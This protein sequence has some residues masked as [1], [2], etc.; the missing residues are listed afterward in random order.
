MTRSELMRVIAEPMRT[1]RRPL[2]RSGLLSVL[3]I[4]VELTQPWPLAIAVDTVITGDDPTPDWFPVTGKTALLALCAVAV[5]ALRAASGLLELAATRSA[6]GAAEQVGAR[7]RAAVFERSMA[8]SLRWHDGLPGG[9]LVSRLTTDVGR[10]L[11]AVVALAVGLIPDVLTLVGVLVLLIAVDPGLAAV[12]A[13]VLPALAVL[14]VLQRRRVRTAQY[15]VRV[16]SGRLA[17]TTTDLIRNVRAV[18]AFGRADRAALIFADRNRAVLDVGLQAVAVE[19]RWA[20]VGDVVLAVGSGLVLLFGGIE[21]VHGGLSVGGLLVVL[22]YLKELYG[23]V[24]SLTRLSTV[25]AKAEASATRVAAVL[26]CDEAVQDAPDAQPA[27]TS[28][29]TIRLDGVAFGYDTQHRVLDD[30]DLDVSAGETVCLFGPSGSG[31]STVLHLLLRLYDVDA[32]RVLVNGIDVRT[33][34]Q[35]SLRDQ[36]AFVPQDPWLLDGT[37]AQNIAFGSRTASRCDVVDAGRRANVDEFIGRLPLGYDSRIGEAGT[38][39]SGGQRRRVAIARAA[40]STASLI[41][42]D[43]PTGSLDAV[44]AG[45]VI[46]AIRA[47]TAHRTTVI[48]TH[49]PALA[50]IADRI[51]EIG[52]TRPAAPDHQPEHLAEMS[53]THALPTMERR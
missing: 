1:Q 29:R 51:I 17:G 6:E 12:G 32:G 3:Q 44:A 19:A 48:V 26:D 14:T 47:A 10:L 35:Q 45:H 38:L 39:L 43:E 42:L 24:R 41:L 40:V 21:V 7:I 31:K 28:I 27:P 53:P 20:P 4:G 15:Q 30:F 8:L 52:S 50:L 2:I 22:A 13:A 37:I 18:Q 33:L 34:Q 23:P 25:L 11:D 46:E 9:E 36:I 49:D 16:E 5:I